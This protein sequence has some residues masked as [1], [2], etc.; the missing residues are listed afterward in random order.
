MFGN[1]K[2]ELW[3]LSDSL[4]E[5]YES[6]QEEYEQVTLKLDSK[7]QAVLDITDWL[8]QVGVDFFY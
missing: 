7:K 4:M 6:K 8:K 5:L 1:T 2:D 3:D